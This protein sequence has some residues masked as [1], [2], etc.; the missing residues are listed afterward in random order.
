MPIRKHENHGI[1]I[2]SLIYITDKFLDLQ[3]SVEKS[4]DNYNI[5]RK[6]SNTNLMMF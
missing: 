3:C 1:C 4:K 5:H 6:P 2:T